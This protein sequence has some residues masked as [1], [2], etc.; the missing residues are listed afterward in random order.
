M[1]LSTS[2]AE[3]ES[4]TNA[5]V[6]AHHSGRPDLPV[7]E[8]VRFHVEKKGRE[9]PRESGRWGS[10]PRTR[11]S[12]FVVSDRLAPHQVTRYELE[13]SSSPIWRG[14]NQIGLELSSRGERSLYRVDGTLVSAAELI[15]F[16]RLV[17]RVHLDPTETA[18]SWRANRS[19]PHASVGN[20][21]GHLV[22]AQE[23]MR[24]TARLLAKQGTMRVTPRTGFITPAALSAQSAVSGVVKQALGSLPSVPDDRGIPVAHPYRRLSWTRLSWTK[25]ASYS[26]V[27]RPFP[28]PMLE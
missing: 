17:S 3:R 19:S 18:S 12:L 11:L 24:P 16:H 26:G 10:G 22:R 2:G 20:T 25:P 28:D 15:D 21:S 8:G 23:E 27:R 13:E 5:W 6:P 1:G 4:P 14:A 9:F 7:E